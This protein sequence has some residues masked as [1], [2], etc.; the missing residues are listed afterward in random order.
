M[1]KFQT[2]KMIWEM[3]K[4]NK[5]E[6]QENLSYSRYCYQQKKFEKIFIRFFEGFF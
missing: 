3:G 4:G 6:K 2:R 5:E 1:L